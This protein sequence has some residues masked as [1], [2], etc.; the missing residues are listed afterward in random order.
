MANAEKLV[1]ADACIKFD[2]ALVAPFRHQN[3]ITYISECAKNP[4]DIRA[5]EENM[6]MFIKFI[7]NLDIEKVGVET[8]CTR[9]AEVMYASKIVRDLND[10]LIELYHSMHAR[11]EQYYKG[12]QLTQDSKV[13]WADSEAINETLNTLLYSND[14]TPDY[15]ASLIPKIKEVY[16]RIPIILTS[17]GRFPIITGLYY[18][19]C[20]RMAYLISNEVQNGLYLSY[21]DEHFFVRN[22]DLVVMNMDDRAASNMLM[23]TNKHPHNLLTC[24]NLHPNGQSI[25]RVHSTFIPS[26][27][28]LG[29]TTTLARDKATAKKA[30]VASAIVTVSKYLMT[31]LQIHASL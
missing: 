13:N 21:H 15:I 23:C 25:M 19:P 16:M 29:N 6:N 30:E 18:T 27:P 24:N 17:Y 3:M 26:A 31:L 14:I 7:S 20:L 28:L 11:I 8:L 4:Q 2:D 1:G 10:R 12:L 9:Y 5:I 22:T